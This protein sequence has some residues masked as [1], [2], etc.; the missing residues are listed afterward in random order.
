MSGLDTCQV[1]GESLLRRDL[2]IKSLRRARAAAAAQTAAHTAA[3]A[4]SAASADSDAAAYAGWGS[5]L[6]AASM[7]DALGMPPVAN[8]STLHWTVMC[9]ATD[10]YLS[11]RS[12]GPR[13]ATTNPARAPTTA[14]AWN[15]SRRRVASP[16]EHHPVYP[17]QAPRGRG[18]L[19]G[20]CTLHSLLR[21]LARGGVRRRG[22]IAGAGF[23]AEAAGRRVLLRRAPAAGSGRAFAPCLAVQCT[24][25]CFS[26]R[27]IGFLSVL[28]FS[29]STETT[30]YINRDMAQGTVY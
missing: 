26:N 16:A 14:L 7:A 8:E 3:A 22:P 1:Q 13:C 24:L 29:V 6:G 9:P 23:P 18:L 17:V 2:L 5:N 30:F 12:D 27:Y 15:P 4:S 25:V 21:L 28:S 10:T 20:D 11:G 19:A